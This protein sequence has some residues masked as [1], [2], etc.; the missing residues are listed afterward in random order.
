V[1]YHETRLRTVI[2][3]TSGVCLKCTRHFIALCLF[4][5]QGLVISIPA[6]YSGGSWVSIHDDVE[7]GSP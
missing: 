5:S 6:P 3:N 1:Q 2:G 7:S 4:V